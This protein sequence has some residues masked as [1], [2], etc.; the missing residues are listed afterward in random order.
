L[1]EAKCSLVTKREIRVVEGSKV[2]LP[3]ASC[4][5][6]CGPNVRSHENGF[7]RARHMVKVYVAQ[8]SAWEY[9]KLIL[10]QRIE[11]ICDLGCD[12]GQFDRIAAN[13][14]QRSTLGAVRDGTF[15]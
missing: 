8:G 4:P 7:K 9:G 6:I 2:K 5:T 10:R 13:L 1:R 11:L 12:L 14:K 3:T 15:H